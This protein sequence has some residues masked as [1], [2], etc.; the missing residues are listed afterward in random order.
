[1]SGT[2]SDRPVL[3]VPQDGLVALDQPL[4]ADLPFTT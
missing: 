1:L 2:S 3:D 4:I